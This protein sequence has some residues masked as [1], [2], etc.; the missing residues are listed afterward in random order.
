MRINQRLFQV[1]TRP[2][3]DGLQVSYDFSKPNT[4]V[5]RDTLKHNDST[6]LQV[7]SS[8]LT[9]TAEVKTWVSGQFEESSS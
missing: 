2:P 1:F 3:E 7:N 8:L 9:A 6:K 4:D 5:H